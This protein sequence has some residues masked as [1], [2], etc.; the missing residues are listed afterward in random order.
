M[1]GNQAW[2]SNDMKGVCKATYSHH[3]VY[4]EDYSIS[5]HDTFFVVLLWLSNDQFYQILS[6]LQEGNLDNLILLPPW[7]WRKPE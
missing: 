5:L 7:E 6:S 4:H 1:I 3:S 2:T